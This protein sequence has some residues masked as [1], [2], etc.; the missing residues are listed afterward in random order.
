MIQSLQQFLSS[1]ILECI[2]SVYYLSAEKL[3]QY[4][5]LQN[6][7][8]GSGVKK[9]CYHSPNATP[10]HVQNNLNSLVIAAH[11]LNELVHSSL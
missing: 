7:W 1:Q 6:I 10:T 9:I 11:K 5:I 3:A 2:K 4:K 8:H